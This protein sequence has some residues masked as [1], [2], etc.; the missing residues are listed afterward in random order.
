MKNFAIIDMVSNEPLCIIP[1]ANGK[2]ALNKF[3]IRL[4]S[5]G[6]YEIH[7]KAEIGFYLAHMEHTSKRLKR[8]ERNIQT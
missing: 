4:M 2:S 5:S 6:F 1:A 7:K 8:I 3:K